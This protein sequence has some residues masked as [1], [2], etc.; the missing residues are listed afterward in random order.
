MS[1]YPLIHGPLYPYSSWC[2]S[3]LSSAPP[4][5]GPQYSSSPPPPPSYYPYYTSFPFPDNSPG[6]SGTCRISS[7]LTLC[8]KTRNARVCWGCCGNF[9]QLDDVEVKHAELCS[10]SAQSGLPMS[11]Y[12][13]AYYHPKQHCLRLKWRRLCDLVIE[14]ST[15]SLL[16]DFYKK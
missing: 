12:G 2:Y 8:F 4:F 6:M 10:F 16:S 5:Y 1:P 3:P 11:K 15:Q 13:N 14:D 7:T 9:T